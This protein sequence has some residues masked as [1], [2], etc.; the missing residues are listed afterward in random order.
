MKKIVSVKRYDIKL[1]DV[2][3]LSNQCS[4]FWWRQKARA[5]EVLYGKF[6]ICSPTKFRI[7]D[8]FCSRVKEHLET[9]QY[10]NFTHFPSTLY[11][12]FQTFQLF[13]FSAYLY[14]SFWLVSSLVIFQEKNEISLYFCDSLAEIKNPAQLALFSYRTT[15]EF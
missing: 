6:A 10:N 11:S 15:C 12:F 1:P 9:L 7:I 4:R 2:T 13:S 14:L 5:R 8:L 3:L